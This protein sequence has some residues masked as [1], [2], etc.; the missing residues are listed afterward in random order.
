MKYKETIYTAI[1][2][3]SDIA[4]QYFGSTTTEVKGSGEYNEMTIV[5]KADT[6]C[7]QIIRTILSTAYPEHRIFGEEHGF[8]GP[9]DSEYT[10][11]IDPID[12]TSN[13]SRNIPIFGISIGLLYNGDAIAGALHFPIEQ[14][15]LYAEKGRGAF[16]NDTPILVSTR[17]L[18]RS[19]YYIATATNESAQQHRLVESVGMTKVFQCSS[20]ELAQIA[21][22]DAEIYELISVLHDVVAGVCIIREAGG[23]VTDSDGSEWNAESKH[24]IAT[25]GIIHRDVL[26]ILNG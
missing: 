4:L 1:Q 23:K 16:E 15:T 3:A 17:T 12:G 19:L 13:F 9:E 26:D 10:W 18:E 7:E 6:E 21:R 24:I 5:T 25:N 22:G 20:Y 11:Y 14:K 2:A 8:S